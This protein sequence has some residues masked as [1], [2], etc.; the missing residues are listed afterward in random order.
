MKVDAV[1]A[2]KLIALAEAAEEAEDDEAPDWDAL[3]AVAKKAL[4]APAP[5][6][7]KKRSLED[8]EPALARLEKLLPATVARLRRAAK[9]GL[10]VRPGASAKA[11]TA[12]EKALG[13][14]LSKE[15]RALLEVFDGGQIGDVV[16][17]GTA[18]GGAVR[19]A[20]LAAFSR[21][22]CGEEQLYTIVAHT[23]RD[24]TIALERGKAA[25]VTIFE[26]KPGWC[27]GSVTRACKSLDVALDLALKGGAVPTNSA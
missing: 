27:G 14:P 23:K 26:G 9:S 17:L 24:R 13:A 22:W 10:A 25:P 2:K 5:R 19:D 18:Q 16:V 1:A 6:L 4:G 11:L 8:L 15:H 20:E 21:A 12:T 3:A 7:V